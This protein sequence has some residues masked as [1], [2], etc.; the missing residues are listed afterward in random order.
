MDQIFLSDYRLIRNKKT[1]VVTIGDSWT[2]GNHLGQDK[3]NLI[4]GKTL[5]DHFDADW[6]NISKCGCSNYWMIDNLYKLIFGNTKNIITDVIY[7]DI[8]GSNWPSTYDEY[9]KNK[10]GQIEKEIEGFLTYNV[11][12]HNLLKKYEMVYIVITLTETGREFFDVGSLFDAALPEQYLENIENFIFEKINDVIDQTQHKILIGRN[13]SINY[14]FTFLKNNLPKTWI[15]VIYDN[16]SEK[17]NNFYDKRSIL[18][19]GPIGLIGLKFTEDNN[20][21]LSKSV[22]REYFIQ[23]VSKTRNVKEYLKKNRLFFNSYPTFLAH[24]MWA[25]YIIENFE[26]F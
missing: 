10:I 22:L 19:Y 24:N 26:K 6:F 21:N 20:L 23:Q 25:K 9:S 12:E 5:A 1:L 8:K 2:W 18:H 4:Y 16:S 17:E 11:Y 15:E 14:P 7:K 3:D 13:F